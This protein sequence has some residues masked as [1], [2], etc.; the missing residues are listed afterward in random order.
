MYLGTKW[1]NDDA[2]KNLLEGHFHFGNVYFLCEMEC[3]GQYLPPLPLIT[4][5]VWRRVKRIL[6]LKLSSHLK[7]KKNFFSNQKYRPHERLK[8]L[9]APYIPL[10]KTTRRDAGENVVIARD[11]QQFPAL[12]FSDEIWHCLGLMAVAI[13]YYCNCQ[14]K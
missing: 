3:F 1:K 14:L 4:P 9:L 7:T 8:N 6:Q 10:D 2:F 13:R 11:G 12:K 5:P